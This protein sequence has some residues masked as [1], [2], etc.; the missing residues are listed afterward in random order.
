MILTLIKN[1]W[2]RP[3]IVGRTVHI[4]PGIV[5]VV[6]IGALLFHGAMAAFLIVPVLLSLF[7]IGKYLRCQILGLPP[8]QDKIGLGEIEKEG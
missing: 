8:F 6:V 4:H 2:L 3:V 7:E 5:F 1:V